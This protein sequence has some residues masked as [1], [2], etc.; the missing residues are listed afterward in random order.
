MLNGEIPTAH[1]LDTGVCKAV[2]S[3][4]Q[5][6]EGVIVCQCLAQ[7]HA[8]RHPDVVPAE[9]DATQGGVRLKMQRGTA[10]ERGRK[11]QR[12]ELGETTVRRVLWLIRGPVVGVSWIIPAATMTNHTALAVG[13]R[14][15]D[16]F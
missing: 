12:L 16:T 13:H 15:S 7:R 9:I 11:H 3:K 14:I 10:P 4:P 8:A 2:V 5:L 6:G 1:R